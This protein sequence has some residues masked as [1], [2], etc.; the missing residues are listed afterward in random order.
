M[1]ARIANAAL[2]LMCFTGCAHAGAHYTI[3]PVTGYVAAQDDGGATCAV[4]LLVPAAITDSVW[5]RC[6]WWQAGSIV[7]QDSV[8][9]ARAVW[10]T[11]N[12]PAE[13]PA[14][15]KVTAAVRVRDGAGT[16]CPAS[17]D[18]TP[19]ATLIKP[20]AFSGLTVAP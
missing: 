4:P 20:A 13:V 6:E 7:K 17:H 3:K 15:S 9:T 2:A 11:F 19:T 5:V 18:Q 10:L 14:S 12:P 1:T 16:S 8:R